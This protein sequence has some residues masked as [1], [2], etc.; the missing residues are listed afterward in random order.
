MKKKYRY[1][2]RLRG[3][4]IWDEKGVKVSD[5][6]TRQ[7]AEAETYRLNGWKSKTTTIN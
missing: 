3:W 5:F 2:P 7:E 1:G 4:A 6:A